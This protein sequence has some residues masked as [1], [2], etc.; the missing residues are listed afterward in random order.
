M[1]TPYKK[2]DADEFRREE[3]KMK[4]YMKELPY[5]D[6]LIQFRLRGKVLNSV[7]THFKSEKKYRDDLWSC[8]GC[9]SFLDTTFHIL[10]QCQQY[11]DLRDNLN[12]EKTEDVVTFFKSVLKKR[13]EADEADDN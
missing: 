10:H 4:D 9:S 6:A 8:E 11:E 2:L 1:M 5:S 3:F 12:L 13:D 7:K